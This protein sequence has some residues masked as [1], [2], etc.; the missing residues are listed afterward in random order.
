MDT[1]AKKPI[2]LCGFMSSGKTTLGQLLAKELGYDFADTDQI[3]V[4]T[5][6]MTIPEMFEK[7]GESYF[8]DLEHETAKKVCSMEHTVIS[9]GGGMLT[10]DRNGEVLSKHGIVVYIDKDFDACY[11]LIAQDANRPLVKM[12]T[13]EQLRELYNKRRAL[14]QKY[15]TVT[16][17]NDGS[18][19]EGLKKLLELVQ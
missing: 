14:Y 8:R 3:L 7:G 16:L 4:D 12:N 11:D 19:E 2:I 6:K 15:A 1:A 18:V 13:K 5:Y 9:T 10:F 17:E